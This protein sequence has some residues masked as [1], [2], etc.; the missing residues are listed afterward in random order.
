M[1]WREYMRLYEYMNTAAGRGTVTDYVSHMVLDAIDDSDH[2][3]TLA[4]LRDEHR[5][6][7][8]YQNQSYLLGDEPM[9]EYWND[10]EVGLGKAV[11]RLE[12]VLAEEQFA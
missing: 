6:A 4:Q 12:E 2:L 11:R 8:E 9:F 5:I 1:T 10:I 7:L 3:S